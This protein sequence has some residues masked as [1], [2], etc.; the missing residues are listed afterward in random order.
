MT[1]SNSHLF[2]ALALAILFVI[3]T[4]DVLAR[5]SKRMFS[6][7]EAMSSEDAKGLLQNDIAFHF[8]DGNH[9][10]I[11]HTIGNWMSNKKTNAFNK[12][13]L[14]A[15]QRAFL[16]A[17]ISLRDRA[18]REGGDGVVNIVSYYKKNRVSSTTEF[19]CG[20]GN[21]IA[22]VTLRGDVVKFK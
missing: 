1:K 17:M 22:G 12:S 5:D 13:D 21:V 4:S 10:A 3:Q 19:E 16:S 2:T 9:P 7:D 18:R 20:A 15:C 6:V 11:E 8:G 14:A